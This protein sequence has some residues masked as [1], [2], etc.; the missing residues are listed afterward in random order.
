MLW[1]YPFLGPRSRDHST[2]I[3][4]KSSPGMG[5]MS[6]PATSPCLHPTA[7]HA[8][9]ALIYTISSADPELPDTI[10]TAQERCQNALVDLNAGRAQE[11]ALL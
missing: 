4:L 9:H 2:Q 3:L 7:V 1:L 5:H 8:P 11:Q 6:G 10:G